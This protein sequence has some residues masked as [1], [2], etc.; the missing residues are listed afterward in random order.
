MRV[1]HISQNS[2]MNLSTASN[3]TALSGW[4]QNGTYHFFS[5]SPP[6]AKNHRLYPQPLTHKSHTYAAGQ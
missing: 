5:N 4:F 1:F 2:V 6:S 3:D